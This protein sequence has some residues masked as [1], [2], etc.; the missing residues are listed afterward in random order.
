MEKIAPKQRT[1]RQNRALWLF[2]EQLADKLNSSGLDMRTVLKPEIDIP[3]TKDLVHDHLW[4]PLQKVMLKSDSTTQMTT[5]DIDKI[6][7]VLV[8]HLGEKFGLTV[9]F[10]SIETLIN[11]QRIK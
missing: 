2:Y 10:P 3:W 7:N 9:T 5:K 8:K 4:I 6:I 11:E 1:I